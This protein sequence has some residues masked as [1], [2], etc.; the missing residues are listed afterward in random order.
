M[1]SLRSITFTA[2]ARAF[3]GGVFAGGRLSFFVTV[4]YQ[5]RS[6][7]IGSAL[8]SVLPP[9]DKPGALLVIQGCI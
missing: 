8:A 5:A 9:V 7:H 3:V 2:S 1:M 4:A 6:F